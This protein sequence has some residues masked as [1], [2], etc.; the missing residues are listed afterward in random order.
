MP[1]IKQLK[2]VEAPAVVETSVETKQETAAAPVVAEKPVSTMEE[3][4]MIE[5]SKV[6]LDPN[7]P[8]E[9]YEKIEELAA[10][11]KNKGFDQA[12]AITVRP[13]PAEAGKFMVIVGHRRTKAALLAGIPAIPCHVKHGY[14]ERDIYEFQLV[15]N[16][17]RQDL[18]PMNR[19]R[20]FDKGIK[21]GI[22][23]TRLSKILGVSLQTLEADMLLLGLAK[24]LH[25][26]V[27][28]GKLPKDVAK[29][30]AL[31]ESSSEQ[32]HIWNNHLISKKTAGAMMA[33]ITAY[34][35]KQ[36]Q[37]DMFGKARKAA[38]DTGLMKH[39]KA[40][41]RLEKVV[42]DFEK[43]SF[44]NDPNTINARKRELEKLKVL[45]VTMRRIADALM[46]NITAYDAK[47]DLEAPKA[48]A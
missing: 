23:K 22:E 34:Q 28:N 10:S 1:R 38:A 39:R 15:E 36:D 24:E 11:M 29:K 19:V 7:Q 31:Y 27:D 20:A 35:N 48:A 40:S 41:E 33:S 8:R 14:S 37:T 4:T 45:A 44:H 3:L 16:E 25:K 42:V 12:F 47:K 30:L 18:P 5:T 17:N 21:M 26:F 9:T 2:K 46:A 6:N 43:G 32:L 13:D